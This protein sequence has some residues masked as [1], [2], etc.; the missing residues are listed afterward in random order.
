MRTIRQVTALATGV[1]IV[2][3]LTTASPARASHKSEDGKLS[4]AI[5]VK[6]DVKHGHS[7]TEIVN[8]FPVTIQS[9][10]LASRGI[11]LLQPAPATKDVKKL[12]ESIHKT[13]GVEYAEPDM[14]V[15]LDDS[16]LH[17]WPYGT[18]TGVLSSDYLSQPLV[19]SLRLAQ[20][21]QRSRGAG[22][23]V[24]VLDTGVDAAQPAL[25]GH[26]SNGYDYVN[27]DEDPSDDSNGIDSD[28]DG[29]RDSA[30]G[31][32]TFVSGL[33]RLVAPD[34]KI[35]PQRVLDS[36]GNGNVFV[37]AQA[38][39][40]AIAQGAKVINLSFGTSSKMKSRLLD[41]VLHNAQNK[42]VVVVAAA[43]N[44]GSNQPHYPAA[45]KDTISVAALDL[46]GGALTD[47][48]NHGKWVRVA[49]P[50]NNIIGPL[51]DG[52]Y[53][54]WSGTSMAAPFVA[55]QAAL[56]ASRYPGL[57]SKDLMNRIS[58]TAK[59]ASKY[60]PRLDVEDGPIDISASV[61]AP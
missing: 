40:D 8:R 18:P 43:G 55:G 19:G 57:R 32:G 35:M 16:R 24:A 3:P 30:T 34:A 6:M 44:D 13:W 46:T 41:D 36:D 11:Y 48:S 23:T 4:G 61:D 9:T 39:Q 56:I 42:G 54:S 1:L 31:H 58:K 28:G 45:R 21:Q 15:N 52:Q 10:V 12:S 60:G 5:V 29:V 33:V 2:L 20:A 38:I 27:D 37:V 7:I 22:V 49:A 50:G 14:S 59:D 26:L 53:A 25:S 51:P 47:F 17:S